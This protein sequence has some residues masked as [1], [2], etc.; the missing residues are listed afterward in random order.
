VTSRLNLFT[1]NSN[2]ILAQKIAEKLK[3][4]LGEA[5]ISRFSDGESRIEILENVR[6][7]DVFIIQSTSAPTNDNLMELLLMSDALRRASAFRI[8][9]VIPYFGYARQ[10]KRP[11]SARVPI[12]AKMVADLI[13]TAGVDRV[14]TVDLHA[15]QIQ[16]FFSI[17]VD[18]VNASK[19]FIEDIQSKH[20]SDAASKVMVVSPDIGGVI[21][22]RTFAEHFNNADLAIIDKRRPKPNESQVMN[23]IGDVKNR[24]CVILD[25]MIDTA[26]TLCLAAEALK[27]Q[28]VKKIVGYCTHAVLSGN[29][30]E[31]IE[32]S[33]LEEVVVTDTIPL[34]DKA[35][36]CSRLRQISCA[37]MLAE[38]IRRVSEEESISSLFR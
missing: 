14:I 3:F 10:D 23:I 16:G 6:G 2:P 36:D 9:A 15:E 30:I 33:P 22:A 12:G 32:H 24:F 4:P 25:D 37:P 35:K 26:G 29:A 31:S 20:A 13:A 18:N 11:R 8:T 19:A 5:K 38:V 21:R 27:K 7:Q 28:G 1:G 34:S 17:P